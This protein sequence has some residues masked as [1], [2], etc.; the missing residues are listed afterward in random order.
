MHIYITADKL[1]EVDMFNSVIETKEILNRNALLVGD[2]KAS[3]ENLPYLFSSIK[4]MKA[5]FKS[6]KRD[7]SPELFTELQKAAQSFEYDFNVRRYK[8]TIKPNFKRLR[9]LAPI[10]TTIRVTTTMT[11]EIIAMC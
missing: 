1:F 3:E 4:A 10:L 9:M 8:F 7:T 5:I 6:R 2:L 11:R